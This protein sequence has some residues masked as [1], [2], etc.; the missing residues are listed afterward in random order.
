MLFA[1]VDDRLKKVTE[2]YKVQQRVFDTVKEES[3]VL[4]ELKKCYNE[5]TNTKP[6]VGFSSHA[7]H[8][9]ITSFV[10][11][12]A[13]MIAFFPMIMKQDHR[14]VLIQQLVSTFMTKVR[15]KQKETN[16]FPEELKKG[17]MLHV[18]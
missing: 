12:H 8:D 10:T 2:F 6:K 1:E 5:D 9:A 13:W 7:S 15:L 18:T 11:H 17:T 4:K 3:K 16:Y 14:D